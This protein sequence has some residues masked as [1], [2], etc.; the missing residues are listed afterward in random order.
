MEMTLIA[1]T[2]VLAV[3]AAGG[4]PRFHPT[5]R[6]G[7]GDAGLARRSSSGRGR[8]SEFASGCPAMTGARVAARPNRVRRDCQRG[9]PECRCGSI[10]CD[11]GSGTRSDR[12]AGRSGAV[13]PHEEAGPIVVAPH[14][15]AW[16]ATGDVPTSLRR[17]PWRLHLN[18]GGHHDEPTDHLREH[19]DRYAEEARRVAATGPAR[20][21]GT[22]PGGRSDDR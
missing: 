8:A 18:P 17:Y 13:C 1:A 2:V 19:T 11:L 20:T 14:A 4:R 6:H 22:A 9:A 7:R 16:S 5:K 10:C 12:Q 21:G 3:D 15:G